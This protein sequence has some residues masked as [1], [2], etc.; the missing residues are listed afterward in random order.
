MREWLY[1]PEHYFLTASDGEVW[2][3]KLGVF[4]AVRETLLRGFPEDVRKKKLAARAAMMAQAGQYNFARCIDRRENGAR[5]VCRFRLCEK[6]NRHGI[7][8]EQ[9][10]YALL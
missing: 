10:V 1:T 9:Q 6:R 8:V 7:S 4:S 3:D 5:A 2:E